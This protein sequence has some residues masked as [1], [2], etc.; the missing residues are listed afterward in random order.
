MAKIGDY[1]HLNY[2]NYLKYSLNTVQSGEREQPNVQQIFDEQTKMLHKRLQTR[3]KYLDLNIEEVE[4]QLN[5]YYDATKGINE[6]KIKS[7]ISQQDLENMHKAIEIFLG[8]KLDNIIIDREK[9]QSIAVAKDINT[10]FLKDKEGYRKNLLML[11]SNFGKINTERSINRKTIEKRVNLLRE[12]RNRLASK[13]PTNSYNLIKE[14]NAISK[15]WGRLQSMMTKEDQG[16]LFLEGEREKKFIEQL[17]DLISKFLTGSSTMH[18][19]YA[20]AVVV[21]T[22]YLV[23]ASAKKG[24]NDILRVLENRVKGQQRSAKGLSYVNFDSDLVDFNQIIGDKTSYT[25]A[26]GNKFNTTITQ[27]KVDVEIEVNGLQVPASLKNINLKANFDIHLLEGR[28]VLALVQ[29]YSTFVN[30]YLNIAAEHGDEPSGYSKILDL[31]NKTMKLTILVKALE[32]G[33]FGRSKSGEIGRS[34]RADLFIINDN[35]IGRFRVFLIDD[36]LTAIEQNLSLLKTGEF[37]TYGRLQ[38]N[39]IGSFNEPDIN[40]ARIRISNLLAQLHS[41]E[42]SVS[43]DK[44]VFSLI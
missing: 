42:L 4:N 26:Y 20:E 18:G 28:S 32:G 23:N 39:Y 3:K 43:I 16:R 27:D 8:K 15:E 36:I 25:D 21:A 40:D 6:E 5:F 2:N 35:S 1:I 22:N 19:E 7:D 30:H 10:K 14:I 17:N 9:L 41:M 44:K 13:D 11:L 33:V 38:N 31:A 37:D 34:Q 24:I 12:A 29:D